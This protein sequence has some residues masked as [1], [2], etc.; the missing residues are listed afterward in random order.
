MTSSF[1]RSL[2][3][4]LLLSVAPLL[5]QTPATPVP[6]TP[7]PKEPKEAYV[8]FWNMLPKEA[9]ALTMLRQISGAE[10]EAIASAAP[11][12]TYAGYLAVKPGRYGLRIVRAAEPENALKTF[13]L[14]LRG[15]VFV[16]FIARVVDRQLTVEMVDDTYDKKEA[17]NGRLT[18]RHEL[19]GATISVAAAGQPGARG[20]AYGQVEKLEGFPAKPVLLKMNAVLADG[21]KRDWAMEVDFR[22]CRHV[23]LLLALDP[24]GRFRPRISPEG[25]REFSEPSADR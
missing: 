5:A 13:D 15:D 1:F 19:P 10:P 21:Q 11:A 14:V 12:N 3:S 25:Q 16:T 6:A 18:V 17:I 4:S 8:R 7:E 9:G 23:T 20:L 22:S 24:Y 2:L